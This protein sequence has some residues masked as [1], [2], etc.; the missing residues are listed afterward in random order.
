MSW[1]VS[2][3]IRAPGRG[4]SSPAAA[5]LH[6]KNGRDIFLRDCDKLGIFVAL[7][8]QRP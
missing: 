7:H 2:C 1:K 4:P 6:R 3:N 5:A 8:L